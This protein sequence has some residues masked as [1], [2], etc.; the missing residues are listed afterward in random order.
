M[1]ACALD[2]IKEKKAGKMKPS[3][4]LSLKELKMKPQMVT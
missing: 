2:E 4:S 3:Y 1:P